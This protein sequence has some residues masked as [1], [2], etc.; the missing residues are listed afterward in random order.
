[1]AEIPRDLTDAE[2]DPDVSALAARLAQS[3]P[4]PGAIFR[5]Q[6]RAFLA[7]VDASGQLIARPRQLW[8]RV[9]VCAIVGAALLLLVAAG[10][11]GW[12]P[13]AT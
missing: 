5:G 7:A 11:G 12:G 1:M 9:A 2:H 8:L 6:V 10:V 4:E 13:F 3:R